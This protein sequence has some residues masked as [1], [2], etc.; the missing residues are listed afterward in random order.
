MFAGALL[1]TMMATVDAERGGSGAGEVVPGP[2]PARVLT[3]IDG[4]TIAVRARIWIGH[5]VETRVRLAA[6]DAPELR[7]G[8][9][10]ERLLAATARDFLIE[11]IGGA[12]VTLTDIRYDK[13]GGRVLAR[14]QTVAGDDLAALLVGAGLGRAYRGG[15]RL[16]WCGAEATVP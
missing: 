11:K 10:R 5:D 9:E 16:S 13:F 6:V 15:K 2:V 12:V 14:V 8:C 3:V 1:A 4:D 7:G